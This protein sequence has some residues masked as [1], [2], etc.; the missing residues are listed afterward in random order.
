MKLD[1]SSFRFRGEG[2]VS[3]KKAEAKRNIFDVLRRRG[4][5]AVATVVV[6][7]VVSTV[8]VVSAIA[9]G[10]IVVAVVVVVVVG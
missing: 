4:S 3:R 7:D 9:T 2:E 8:A 6:V 10:V 1:G 5:T